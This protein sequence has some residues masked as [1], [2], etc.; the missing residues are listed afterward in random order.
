MAEIKESNDLYI[1]NDKW[2]APFLLAASFQNL[3]QFTGSFTKNGILYWQ[4]S[5]KYKALSL[6]EQFRT[7]TNPSI[8]A[9]DLFEAITVF[10]QQIA[11]TKKSEMNYG[12][13]N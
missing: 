11:K 3:I 4:F 13:K 5:P 7:K 12:E 9:R 8:P 2:N 6:V 10:W 1:E